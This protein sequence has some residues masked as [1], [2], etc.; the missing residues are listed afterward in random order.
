MASLNPLES[1]ALD[2]QIQA[3]FLE[4]T[5]KQKGI[6][7]GFDVNTPFTPDEFERFSSGFIRSA[8]DEIKQGFDQF[9][10]WDSEK[11]TALIDTASSKL[12]VQLTSTCTVTPSN[13]LYYPTSGL[14]SKIVGWFWSK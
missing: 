11:Q 2:R 10:S 6:S 1:A 9:A 7:E 4:D 8:I 3:L 12:S 14:V 5:F 13:P